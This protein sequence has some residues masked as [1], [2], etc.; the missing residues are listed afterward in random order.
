VEIFSFHLSHY[1]NWTSHFSIW[2][3][4]TEG[5]RENIL[6]KRG[7]NNVEGVLS[8][9]A[10][11][12]SYEYCSRGDNSVSE[13][14]LHNDVSGRV[15]CVVYVLIKTVQI[16]QYRLRDN[17]R[18]LRYSSVDGVLIGLRANLCFTK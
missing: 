10:L 7:T 9:D 1:S 12:L 15:K 16:K 2:A 8:M 5:F 3:F 14:S 17:S 6:K 11:F 4:F 18:W 13:R